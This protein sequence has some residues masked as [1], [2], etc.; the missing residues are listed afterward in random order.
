MMK[1]E[2]VEYRDADQTLEAYV[3]FD[4]AST[5]KR[6][7]V[8]I[9]HDW[10]G[11]R[12]HACAGAE[13]M[14]ELGY[15]GFAVD[16]YGKGVFGKDGD[17][18][19]N[20][21]LMMPFAENRQALR[22]RMLAALGAARKLS[23]VDGSNIAAIG[24]CFGGMAVLELARSGADVKGVAS[25]H[26]LLGQ[27]DVSSAA[28]KSKVLCLHGH[29]DPMVTP[30]QVLSFE[31]EMSAAGVDWQVHVYGGTSHAFTNP[32][33]NNRD[34][35]T[36]YNQRASQRAEKALANFFHELFV[37]MPPLDVAP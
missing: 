28:I 14:A 30:E 25:V 26:G 11:R 32:A 35:G 12:A 27:G 18:Q 23:Q 29:D 16:I 20:S 10:T 17:V 2:Y 33:A 5:Q 31:T 15:V 7:C 34:L 8:L 21:A 22:Q 3:A 1:T 6:P 36:V 24:Y 4:D 9:A 13:R 19:G 37:E